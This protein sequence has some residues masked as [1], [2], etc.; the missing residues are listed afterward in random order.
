NYMKDFKGLK[1]IPEEK[2]VSSIDEKTL[3][4]TGDV[5]FIREFLYTYTWGAE[6]YA[7][8]VQEQFGYF[9]LGEYKEFFK[10]MGAKI[11]FAEELLEPGYPDNL[12]K[13]LDLFD[14][15]G[16]EAVYPDSNCIII[17]EK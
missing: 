4:V 11:I 1:D 2:K 17:V 14:E 7:H 9:T 3:T 5:N 12:G 15:S 10:E 8:E 13:L 16:N 6:S